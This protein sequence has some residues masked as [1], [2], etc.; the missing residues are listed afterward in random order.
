MTRGML[1]VLLC[2]S[3]A[4]EIQSKYDSQII[5]SYLCLLHQRRSQVFVFNSMFYSM[6]LCDNNKEDSDN[7]LLKYVSQRSCQ[8]TQLDSYRYLAMPVK[9]GNGWALTVV[10]FE[11]REIRGPLL[12]KFRAFLQEYLDKTPNVN[13]QIETNL[14]LYRTSVAASIETVAE[15]CHKLRQMCGI[16]LEL[17]S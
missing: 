17:Q 4:Q 16:N 14:N 9:L 13:P 2:P 6:L 7:K 10:D 5:D 15:L 3:D 8:F 12:F 11:L 1:K